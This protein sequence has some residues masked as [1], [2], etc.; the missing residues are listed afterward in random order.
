MKRISFTDFTPSMGILID[1]HHPVDYKL[2]PTPEAIN[3]YADKL[4]MDSKH[5]LNPVNKYYII[6][7]VIGIY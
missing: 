2:N 7:C 6:L 1:V 4:L 3:I 5:Y